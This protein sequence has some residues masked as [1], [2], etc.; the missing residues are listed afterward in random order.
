MKFT[1]KETGSFLLIFLVSMLLSCKKFVDVSPSI[2][3]INQENV[4]SNASTAT[5]VLTNI[6]SEMSKASAFAFAGNLGISVFCGLSAD[7][8][9]LS[10]GISDNR[11]LA[12]YKNELVA[13]SLS[14]NYGSEF[15]QTPY[16]LIFI[17]NSALEGIN[18]SQK[19]SLDVK[20][21]LTG[22]ARFVRA[23]IYFYLVNLFGDVPMPLTTDYKVNR[24]L[25]R[26]PEAS[27]YEQ[28]I[29]DLKQAQEMLSEVYIDGALKPYTGNVERIRPNKWAATA[30]LARAYLYNKDYSKAEIEASKLIE[31]SGLFNLTALNSVF[32]KNSSECIWSLQGVTLNRNTEDGLTFI[33]PTSGP[34]NGNDLSNPVYLSNSLLNSFEPDDQRK[35]VGNWISTLTIPASIYYFSYKYK[36][37][38]GSTPGQE[39]LVMLR[40][41]EQYLIRAEARAYLNN[42]AGAQSD[43]NLIR[44]R[45]GL[46][47]TPAAD[48]SSLLSAILIERRHE[49]FTEMGHRWFDLKR[50]E[51]VNSVMTDETPIKS[52]GLPWSS[53][54]QLYPI[55][56]SDI[57]GNPNLTQNVGY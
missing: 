11:Y 4:Y 45:A 5:S 16:N 54:Q 43:L 20:K 18:K 32:L 6:Y 22:E 38:A 47:D 13:Q 17:C 1:I 29:E 15:W 12:Y 9:T 2:T 41:A 56:F 23:F 35:L 46:S 49:L 48:K 26:L 30:L 8:L 34:S 55:L 14:Q 50:T 39:Y 44:N 42:I 40:L 51:N 57:L 28:I 3:S 52:N 36:Q 19:L 25:S 21:Q 37:G 24:Y 10:S 31:N 7:E 53:Y 33:I 27:V